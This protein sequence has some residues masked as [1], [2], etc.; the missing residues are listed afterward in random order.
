M[1][2]LLRIERGESAV[3]DALTVLLQMKKELAERVARMT[4]T[5]D[6][7][8]PLFVLTPPGSARSSRGRRASERSR[9]PMTFL[10][11]RAKP[12]TDSATGTPAAAPVTPA[13]SAQRVDTIAPQEFLD[14]GL[15]ALS[16]FA[17]RAHKLEFGACRAGTRGRR[18][19]QP[20]C[21]AAAAGSGQFRTRRHDPRPGEIR[22]DDARQRAGRLVRPSALRRQPLDLGR[23]LA[24]P[25]PRARTGKRS[26]PASS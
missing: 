3:E 9:C 19:G 10:P 25:D 17:A 12:D 2:T 14:I 21:L 16:D 6:L 20:L 26:V 1:L 5:D 23:H 11:K 15:E 7:P 4:V 24:A 22:Q 13:A 8:R 18:R